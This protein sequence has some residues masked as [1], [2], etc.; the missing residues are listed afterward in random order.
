MDAFKVI[1]N[2]SEESTLAVF[3]YLD[4]LSVI[5]LL[6]KVLSVI[7]RPLMCVRRGRLHL[8]VVSDGPLSS[9]MADQ[10]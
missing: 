8:L 9:Q 4:L 3:I 7:I 2:N 6:N 5:S 10:Q 1:P